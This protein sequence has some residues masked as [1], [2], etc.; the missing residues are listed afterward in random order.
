MGSK[1]EGEKCV[2]LEMWSPIHSEGSGALG[3]SPPPESPHERDFMDLQTT[4]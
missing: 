2:E 4:F 1:N 3:F